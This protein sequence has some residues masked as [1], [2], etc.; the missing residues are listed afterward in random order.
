VIF[1]ALLAY[2]W[3]GYKVFHWLLSEPALEAL[4][5]LMWLAL[6]WLMINAFRGAVNAGR[7]GPL[8]LSHPPT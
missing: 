7:R 5:V 3:N 1:L 6:V 2:F 8:G 4:S